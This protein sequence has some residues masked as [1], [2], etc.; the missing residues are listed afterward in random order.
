MGPPS[1]IER[2]IELGLNRYGAGDLDGALLM[3]EEALAIDPDNAR[4]SSY[5]DYVRLHYELLSSEPH[6]EGAEEAPF[7][8]E[9]EPEY[10][11]EILPGDLPQRESQPVLANDEVDAGW[12]DEEATHDINVHARRSSGEIEIEADAPPR[13]SSAQIE[14]EA[15]APPL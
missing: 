6:V 5:V 12:F 3:W 4:A 14:I 9:E 11:I 15:E 7:G 8:I 1:D 2:L 13:R 10:Q